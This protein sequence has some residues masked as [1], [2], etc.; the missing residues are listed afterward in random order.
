MEATLTY[1]NDISFDEIKKGIK[2]LFGVKVS[3]TQKQPNKKNQT[4]K[5]KKYEKFMQYAGSLT[6]KFDDIDIE[7]MRLNKALKK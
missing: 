7:D 2:K 1:S 6:G 5:Q 3:L 4:Q